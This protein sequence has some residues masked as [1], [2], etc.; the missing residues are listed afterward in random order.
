MSFYPAKTKKDYLLCRLRNRDDVIYY[1]NIKKALISKGWLDEN[2]NL[3]KMGWLIAASS[4]PLKEQ[5]R[6]L[7]IPYNKIR[8][9]RKNKKPEFDVLN[10]FFD[11]GWKGCFSEGG[12]IFILLEC[13]WYDTLKKYLIKEQ[14][15]YSMFKDADYKEVENYV[16]VSYL[17]NAKC[18][19]HVI[20]NFDI[21][22]ELLND[23]T[24]SNINNIL[25]KYYIM[26]KSNTPYWFPYDYHYIDSYLIERLY[27]LSEIEQL[28]MFADIHLTG[29]N[30]FIESTGFH[31]L[32]LTDGKTM[33]FIEVKTSD[34]LQTNQIYQ[35]DIL[36]NKCGYNVE[37]LKVKR[38]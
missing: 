9:K 17:Y 23:I 8:L 38:I 11:N 28:L 10:H 12:I 14:K 3:T 27:S 7:N 32:F 33:K 24:N 21:K 15:K 31:D 30:G 34:K 1:K 26:K 2:N 13:I 19:L 35:S 37:V 22:V 4:C 36:S 6:I 25:E 16:K 20:R 5:C 18:Y 29:F